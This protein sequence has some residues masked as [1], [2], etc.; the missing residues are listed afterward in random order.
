[1][2]AECGYVE[3][4]AATATR[5]YRYRHLGPGGEVASR[6][7]TLISVFWFVPDSYRQGKPCV[8]EAFRG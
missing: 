4:L 8:C 3:Y 6:T 1:M 7:A 2:S 5:F